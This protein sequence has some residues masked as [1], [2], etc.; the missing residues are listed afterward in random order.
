M[1][2]LSKKFMP[3]HHLFWKITRDKGPDW[4][5]HEA[6]YGYPNCK[7]FEALLDWKTFPEPEPFTTEIQALYETLLAYVGSIYK[8]FQENEPPRHIFRR[9]FCLGVMMP[10]EVIGLVEERRPR[11]LAILA[12]Y[13]AMAYSLNDH[14]V[15]HGLAD[16]E[17]GGIASILPNEWQ[18][19]MEWPR[20]M[21]QELKEKPYGQEYAYGSG[22]RTC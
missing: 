5:N 22:P 3:N 18:W 2:Q 10:A 1:A 7:P 9:L 11:A 6:L 20:Q 17:V 4:D 12:H 16:Q 14:W 21:L 13:F 19:A 8:A 15:W